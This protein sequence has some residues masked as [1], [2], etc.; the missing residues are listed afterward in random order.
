MSIDLTDEQINYKKGIDIKL[1]DGPDPNG[2]LLT[3]AKEEL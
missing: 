1:N 3:F 2:A